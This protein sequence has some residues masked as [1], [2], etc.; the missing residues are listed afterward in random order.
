MSQKHE[1]PYYSLTTDVIC[2]LRVSLVFV[3]STQQKQDRKGENAYA[4]RGALRQL[5]GWSCYASA[6]QDEAQLAIT[7]PAV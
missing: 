4:E 7:P 3:H 1:L 6:L 2:S 5:S